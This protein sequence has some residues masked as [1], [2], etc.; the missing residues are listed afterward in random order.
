MTIPRSRI[1][2]V[3]LLALIA[4]GG[5]LWLS[6]PPTPAATDAGV[7]ATSP[8]VASA[9]DLTPQGDVLGTKK[10][11][12]LR[13]YFHDYAATSRYTQ[14]QVEGFYVLLDQLWRN[15][16]YN[17]INITYTVSSLY[18]LPDNRSA[19]IDDYSDGDLSGGSKFG[20]VLGDAIAHAPAGLDWTNVDAVLVVMAETN[21]AQFHRGQGTSSCSLHMGP[22][23][24]IKTVGCAIFSE[25]PSDTDL[26]IWG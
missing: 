16:S 18:Q 1:H 6:R 4:L 19:Y 23:G 3:W 20:K 7:A 13:V 12:V 11:M 2:W 10:V 15:T 5:F 26:Q 21:P 17:K 8:P 22:G 25:N 9:A 24:P 14:A